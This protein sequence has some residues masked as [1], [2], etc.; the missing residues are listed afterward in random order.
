MLF[1]LLLLWLILADSYKMLNELSFDCDSCRAF[2]WVEVGS[3]IVGEAVE[4]FF[5]EL[6]VSSSVFNDGVF[7][8]LS[9]LGVWDVIWV[10]SLQPPLNGFGEFSLGDFSVT[11]GVNM[12]EDFIG[13]FLRDALSSG[14]IRGDFDG[15]DGGDEGEEFHVE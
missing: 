8:L 11:V 4:L 1:I 14:G 7:E 15:R 13:L 9:F 6:S 12:I 10:G 5:V 2:L 3:N